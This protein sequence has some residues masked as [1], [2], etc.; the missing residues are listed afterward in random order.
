MGPRKRHNLHYE[1]YDFMEGFLKTLW[2][3]IDSQRENFD[4]VD[5]ASIDVVWDSFKMF[6]EFYGYSEDFLSLIHI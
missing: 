6:L 3:V 4:T 5:N 1:K 2:E